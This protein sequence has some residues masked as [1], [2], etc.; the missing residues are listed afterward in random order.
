MRTSPLILDDRYGF[1]SDEKR[2]NWLALLARQAPVTES[3]LTPKPGLA[4]R[5]GP[6]AHTDLSLGVGRAGP[7]GDLTT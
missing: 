6:G 4:D 5:R 3:E 1:V 7:V 2:C